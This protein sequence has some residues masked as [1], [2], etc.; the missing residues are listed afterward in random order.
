MTFCIEI[1]KLSAFSDE[2]LLEEN[3]VFS[4]I[5]LFAQK[6]EIMFCMEISKFSAFSD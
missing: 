3:S 1:S 2:T 4:H 5:L 6:S